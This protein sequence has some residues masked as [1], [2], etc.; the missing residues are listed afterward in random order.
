MERH[1]YFKAQNTVSCKNWRLCS[2]STEK[3]QKL[4]RKIWKYNHGNKHRPII[5]WLEGQRLSSGKVYEGPFWFC[6]MWN[7]S[8]EEQTQKRAHTKKE[9]VTY[10]QIHDLILTV[11]GL[12]GFLSGVTILLRSRWIHG[13]VCRFTWGPTF[14]MTWDLISPSPT[15]LPQQP[16]MVPV[17]NVMRGML[18]GD[19]ERNC[20]NK[21][22]TTPQAE[23]TYARTR[24]F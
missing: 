7:F 14:T 6:I 21:P 17:P 8:W 19:A 4:I 20:N 15:P 12:W 5:I 3:K 9:S 18:H 1:P 23:S 2:P 10:H 11:F 22:A 13:I 16:W 24:V